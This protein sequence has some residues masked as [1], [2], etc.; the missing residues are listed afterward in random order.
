MEW[1]ANFKKF[2]SLVELKNN[3]NHV[4]D[5]IQIWPPANWKGAPLKQSTVQDQ[6]YATD[7]LNNDLEM[8]DTA[9]CT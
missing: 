5:G 7:V 2:N 3:H 6:V 9:E 8:I 1:K 4:Q